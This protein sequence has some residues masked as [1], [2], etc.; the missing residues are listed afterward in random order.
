M[1]DGA[2]RISADSKSAVWLRVCLSTLVGLPACGTGLVWLGAGNPL[3]LVVLVPAL[4]LG[5]IAAMDLVGLARGTGT[6]RP[7]FALWLA[8]AAAPV[9][10]Y[11]VW[12]GL[13]TDPR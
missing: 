13:F 1:N 6:A 8:I 5:V 10:Y 9:V 3:G 11:V 4:Y 7:R 2:L 12:L